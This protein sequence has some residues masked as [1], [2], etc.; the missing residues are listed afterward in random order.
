METAKLLESKPVMDANGD[1]NVLAGEIG[2][3]E[4]FYQI[5]KIPNVAPFEYEDVPV[6]TIFDG[7]KGDYFGVKLDLTLGGQKFRILDQNSEDLPPSMLDISELPTLVP[8]TEQ[9]QDPDTIEGIDAEVTTSGMYVYQKAL[10]QRFFGNQYLGVELV[11]DEVE[12]YGIK[13]FPFTILSLL[14]R[15]DGTT[16]IEA[17]PFVSEL[18]LYAADLG[19]DQAGWSG[20]VT[21]DDRSFTQVRETGEL[22]N[23]EHLEL[24]PPDQSDIEEED[25][26]YKRVQKYWRELNIDVDPW[27]ETVFLSRRPLLPDTL[28]TCSCPAYGKS[29]LRMPETTENREQRKT[30]R[31]MNY[32]L[33]TVLG[34]ERF[35]GLGVNNS[36]GII[37]SWESKS[38]SR[39]Y[40]MCKHTVASMFIDHLKVKEPNSYP[41]IETRKA[42][43]EKLKADIAEVQ[44]RFYLSLERG[45][46]TTT[47]II[48]ALAQGLNLDDVELAYVMLNSKF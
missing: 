32:P 37:E 17:I 1:L 35:D 45:E 23:H 25:R 38:E 24:D 2:F 44:D 33:P 43:E 27:M 41:S 13:L 19:P 5:R 26:T 11:R 10:Y 9:D 22:C 14:P 4:D 7:D 3:L 21:F 34:K 28:Y 16:V 40:K 12:Y 42:F 20:S 47:E 36:A 48:F 30:N 29:I 15:P 39:R 8:K 31:Q 6:N 18:E 46:I